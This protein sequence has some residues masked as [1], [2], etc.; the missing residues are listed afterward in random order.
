MTIDEQLDLLCR[1][2]AEVISRED[3]KTKLQSGRTLNIKLGVDPTV[4]HVTLGWG[5]VLRKLRHFQ[6]CGHLACLIIGDFTAQIGDPSG[7]S[8]TRPQLSRD[9][10]AQNVKAVESQ[11][12]KILDPEKTKLFYNADWL[13][14]MHFS[15]V[16]KLASN[17]TVARILERDDFQNRL[18]EEKPIGLHEILY[19]LCQGYDSVA[20][21]ADVELGGTDQKFNNLV[22]RNLQREYEQDPQVVMLMPLLVGTDGIEKMSQSLGNYVS[23]VDEPNEMYGKTMS[24]PDHLIE[25]WFTLCTDVPLEE[26][27]TMVSQMTSGEL[28]PRD[29]KR[30]LAAELVRIYH[31]T[32]AAKEADDYFVNTFSKR[33]T[34]IDAE[35]ATIPESVVTDGN[36]SVPHLIVAL[37]L[38]SS[39]GEARRLME[40]GGVSIGETTVRDPRAGFPLADCDGRV[41]RVGKHKFRTL[42][43]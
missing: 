20:I 34:P 11:L 8:K 2:C 10:V 22:G 39:N 16:I 35:E 1:G 36:V 29:A 33:A 6:D 28:N 30:K 43:I 23:V 7:K 17:I 24:I 25:S 42:K 15:D 18:K 3:L 9:Q 38:A 40:Q 31:S 13:D 5:V 27:K 4:P 37:K 19:P 12:F 26:V 14:A 41:L 32:E 21:K